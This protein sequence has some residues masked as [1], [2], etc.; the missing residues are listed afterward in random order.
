MLSVVSVAAVCRPD[1]LVVQADGGSERYA[2][3]ADARLMQEKM[4]TVLR[5]A[6]GNGHGQIVL[7]AF[8][9]GAFGNP[10][11]EVAGMWKGVLLEREFE[12]GL[13]D[14]VVFAVL[15]ND[16]RGNFDLFRERLEGVAV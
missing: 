8:G 13:W 11:E 7:G 3:G 6:A 4:R 16:G 5:V 15:D 12:G 2:H 1:L 10:G 9:C 14:D